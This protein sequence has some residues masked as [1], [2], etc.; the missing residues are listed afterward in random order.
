M[1]D[2]AVCVLYYYKVKFMYVYQD[3]DQS[4]SIIQM[5]IN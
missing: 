4:Q 1:S 3:G 5:S 2:Y